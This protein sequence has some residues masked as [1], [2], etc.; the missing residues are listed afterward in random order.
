MSALNGKV[1]SDKGTVRTELRHLF[2]DESA[3]ERWRSFER[4]LINVTRKLTSEDKFSVYC[5]AER[6]ALNHI[7]RRLERKRL[8]SKAR[9]ATKRLPH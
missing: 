3:V 1:T 7:N 9:R 6:L 8:A 5:Y 2:K 4:H